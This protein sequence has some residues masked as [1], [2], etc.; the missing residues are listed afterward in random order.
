MEKE[1]VLSWRREIRSDRRRRATVSRVGGEG[2][3]D[4]RGRLFE[5]CWAIGEAG[6]TAKFSIQGLGV[7]KTGATGRRNKSN[8]TADRDETEHNDGEGGR[9]G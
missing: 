6:E 5:S 2:G 9:E 7:I 3:G 1:E 8:S 4:R